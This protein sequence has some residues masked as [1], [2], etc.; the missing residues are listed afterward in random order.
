MLRKHNTSKNNLTAK[1]WGFERIKGG[2]PYNVSHFFL[3]LSLYFFFL[4]TFQQETHT[5]LHTSGDRKDYCKCAFV[6]VFTCIYTCMHPEAH[7]CDGHFAILEGDYRKEQFVFSYLL[8]QQAPLVSSLRITF[9]ILFPPCSN[10]PLVQ[11][12]LKYRHYK[13]KK[14]LNQLYSQKATCEKSDNVI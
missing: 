3:Y 12:I 4:S 13:F 5:N 1:K 10:A 2:L 9:Y 6:C 7:S 8:L 14:D 11:I